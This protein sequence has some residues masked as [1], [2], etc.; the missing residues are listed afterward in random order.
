M[1]I[2]P[3]AVFSIFSTLYATGSFI[4]SLLSKIPEQIAKYEAVGFNLG[5]PHISIH[6]FA[7]NLG[8]AFWVASVAVIITLCILWLS[9]SVAN[10]KGRLS[11]EVFYYLTIYVFIVPLWLAKAT[12]STIARQSISWK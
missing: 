6:W 7:I 5:L 11:K 3:I 8:T 2:L 9:L 10:G 1:F 12:Y 4:W